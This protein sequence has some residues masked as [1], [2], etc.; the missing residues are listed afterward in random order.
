MEYEYA[1]DQNENVV[2]LRDE[3]F[4]SFSGKVDYVKK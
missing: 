1:K 2:Q 4:N 3:K